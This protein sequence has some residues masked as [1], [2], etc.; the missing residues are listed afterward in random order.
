MRNGWEFHTNVL[1]DASGDKEHMFL[2]ACMAITSPIR[3]GGEEYWRIWRRERV[4]A[5][6]LILSFHQIE[7]K[8]FDNTQN[9]PFLSRAIL[10]GI[11]GS[12]II[13]TFNFSGQNVFFSHSKNI[14]VF[15]GISLIPRNLHVRLL[16]TY[17]PKLR[18]L[19]LSWQICLNSCTSTSQVFKERGNTVQDALWLELLMTTQKA[20][21]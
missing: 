9:T 14:W 18:S 19:F 20:N 15:F 4:S 7:K 12:N 1:I 5:P 21:K 3:D 16:P 8:W 2:V 17:Y 11:R 6:N 10:V 13:L